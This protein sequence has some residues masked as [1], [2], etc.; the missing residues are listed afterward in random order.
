MKFSDVMQQVKD[1]EK[2]ACTGQSGRWRQQFCRNYSTVINQI[3]AEHHSLLLKKLEAREE[4]IS[5]RKGCSQC[6]YQHIGIS[7]AHGIYITDYLYSNSK[8]QHAFL[9]DYANWYAVVGPV[10]EEIDVHQHQ[11]AAQLKKYETWWFLVSAPL[12]R[13]FRLAMPCP[14]L[15]DGS[16]T[17]YSLR[18]AS[19]AGHY[20]VNPPELCSANNIEGSPT[21]NL[22]LRESDCQKLVALAPQELFVYQMTMP[23]LIYRLLTEGLMPILDE[24]NIKSIKL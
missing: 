18:S 23:I 24:L 6:C 4:T 11:A 21:Y 12:N 14:F 2:K 9:K 17:I 3:I 15:K 20:S 22:T 5:C 7:L 13:Y 16:C 8:L 19:C 1:V 10:S